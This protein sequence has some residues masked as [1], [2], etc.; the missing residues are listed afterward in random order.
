MDM[1]RMPRAVVLGDGTR[2][3]SQKQALK[4]DLR[5]G[6]SNKHEICAPA[7]TDETINNTVHGCHENDDRLSTGEGSPTAICN[8]WRGSDMKLANRLT[9]NVPI[10]QSVGG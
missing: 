10:R 8:S 7:R 5:V 4:W 6:A 9:G 1:G 2:N 3:P